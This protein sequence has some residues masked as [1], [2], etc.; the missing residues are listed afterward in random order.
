MI[1]SHIH[2]SVKKKLIPWYWFLYDYK[3]NPIPTDDNNDDKDS[4]GKKTIHATRKNILV[5]IMT[6]TLTMTVMAEI[7]IITTEIT[8]MKIPIIL[9]WQISYCS[10]EKSSRHN[11]NKNRN[12]FGMEVDNNF[13]IRE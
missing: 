13:K 10:S 5:I 8:D 3:Y 12:N 2:N 4:E 9:F 1:N 7:L 6:E 11:E